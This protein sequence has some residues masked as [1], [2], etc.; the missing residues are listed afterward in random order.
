MKTSDFYFELPEE[1]IAQTPL[2]QR[3]G[4]RLLCLDKTSGEVRHRMFTD[5]PDL[6][7]PGDCLV[8]KDSRVIPA[9]LYGKRETGGAVEL[10]LL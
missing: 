7:N 4:S 9:R 2:E 1:L 8:M 5:L 10:M 6:L 3:D